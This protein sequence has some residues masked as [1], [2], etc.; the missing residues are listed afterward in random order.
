MWL[1]MGC[2]VAAEACTLSPAD[3]IFTRL[4]ASDNIM[5]GARAPHEPSRL[6]GKR[7]GLQQPGRFL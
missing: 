6:R 7:C 4:G 5:A 1:Q 3:R 2:H